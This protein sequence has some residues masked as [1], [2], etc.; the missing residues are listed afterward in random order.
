[1]NAEEREREEARAVFE[2]YRRKH[3]NTR[4]IFDDSP[5]TEGVKLVE[6]ELRKFR[7]ERRKRRE[8]SEATPTESKSNDD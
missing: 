7:E 1:M 3:P 5:P 8:A 6:A 2:S 4:L